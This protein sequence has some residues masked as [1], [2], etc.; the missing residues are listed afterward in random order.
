MKVT[1][2]IETLIEKLEITNSL[3]GGTQSGDVSLFDGPGLAE[4][5]SKALSAAMLPPSLTPEDKSKGL[6]KLLRRDCKSLDMVVQS[7]LKKEKDRHRP[8]KIGQESLESCLL[9]QTANLLYMLSAHIIPHL[10]R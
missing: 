8:R 9:H 5:I 4:E 7:L 3:P 2:N 10:E 1:I 6:A